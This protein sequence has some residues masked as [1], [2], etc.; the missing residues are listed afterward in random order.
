MSLNH[1]VLTLG[2]CGLIPFVGLA[3]L[4]WV[5]PPEYQPFI[6]LGLTGYAAAIISFLG[7]IH[8]GIGL[9]E[10]A[11]YKNFH[12]IWGVIPSL[13][14]WI[15][16]IMPA[17]AALPMLA[18]MLLIGYWVDR[19]TWPLVG[20]EQWLKMRLTLTLVAF[21]SCLVALGAT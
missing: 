17:Y 11:E 15:G 20:L 18:L 6:A 7:G 5:A 13:V 14:A 9:K 8:W 3:L 10:E 16:V 4:I 2:Y 1:K 19:K 12:F 21:L